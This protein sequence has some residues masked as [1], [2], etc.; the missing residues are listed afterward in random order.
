MSITIKRSVDIEDEVRIALKDHL[1][2]YCRPLPKDFSL[3]CILITQVGG[4]DQDGQIDTFEVTLDARA[5]NA[6]DANETLRNALGVLR[7]A[8]GDQTT[9]IRFVEV[10]SSGSWG[11]DPA[12][13]DLAMYSARIRVVAHLETKSI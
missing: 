3:P 6:A 10:N 2:A 8:A 12:R 7:K 13:P 9:A 1:T 5:S 4:T 11:S